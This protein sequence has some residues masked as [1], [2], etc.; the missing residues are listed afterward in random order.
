M[1]T[2][3][4]YE[5]RITDLSTEGKGI[6]RAEEMVT[7]VP[8]LV[9]GDLASVE[10]TK[11][12]KHIAEGTCRDLLQASPYRTESQCRYDRQCGGCAM[13]SLDYDYQVTLK[14]QQVRNQMERL[15]GGTLPEFDPPV[16]MEEPWRYRN[17][18]EYAVY[19]GGVVADDQKGTVRNTGK[20][21][22]GYYDRGS[23]KVTDVRECLLQSEAAEMAA[24]GLR[25]YLQESGMTV[26]D[27]ATRR[28]KLRRMI[29]RVGAATGQV[30]VIVVINGKKLKNPELLAEIL[31]EA[32]TGSGQ[33]ELCSIAVEYNTAKNVAVPGKVEV[34]AGSRTIRD[35]IAG[36][37]LEI[38]PQSFYQV[39]PGMMEQLYGTVREYAQLTGK[40][41]V[42][43]LYCGAGTIGL[44]CA[45]QAEYVWGIEA[46]DQAI[47][48]ANR[49][50]VLNGAVNIRF[51]H[52]R[53]EE[54]IHELL[55]QSIHPDVVIL[56]PPRAGCKPE[57]LET[58]LQ[59]G[60]DRII[61]VSCDPPT[62]ARDLRIL[63][64][65]GGD[66][67]VSRVRVIDQFCHTMRA[68]SVILLSRQE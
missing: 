50:A 57:L 22:I 38:S 66:Y 26:Y 44:Y 41:T 12:R 62:Q 8:G 54:T 51:L 31:D 1:R 13:Q 27:P 32:I 15:Y 11:I 58:V 47:L 67:H 19:A 24:Y 2:G 29:V 5:I 33:F 48:D 36:M 52:G 46:V 49:N 64:P 18:T 35:R 7:F 63:A 21:R 10:I 37:E 53:A 59:A 40:E 9:P 45:D 68:E 23:R 16:G 14:N 4:T 56:D 55:E 25:R 30:M 60:P 65:E 28:G 42:F 39:N 17:K 6:G 20:L 3:E 43:D 34:I 61:Y